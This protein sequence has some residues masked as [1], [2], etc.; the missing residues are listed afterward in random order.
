[1]IEVFSDPKVLFPTITSVAAGIW[2]LKD[3]L[4]KRELYPKPK[5]EPGIKSLRIANGKSIALIW[6]RVKNFGIVR[7][8]IDRAEFYVRHLHS[9]SE[10]KTISI[11]GIPTVDF[12]L[13]V[14]DTTPLFPANWK[15]SYVDGG[16]ETEYRFTVSMPSSPGLYSI[17]T[18]VFLREDKSDFIQDITFYKMDLQNKFEKV[19][20]RD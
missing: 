8:Y 17:H 6:I 16:G 11:D 13:K 9:D 4:L 2:I 14:V 20:T 10:H 18:K 15:Y 1:M 19:D 3:F 5:I 7:L 12:P